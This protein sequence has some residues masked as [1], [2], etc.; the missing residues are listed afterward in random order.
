VLVVQSRDAAGCS[1]CSAG[2]AS[3]IKRFVITRS[4]FSLSLNIEQDLPLR[5]I[6]RRRI[7]LAIPADC[8]PWLTDRIGSKPVSFEHLHV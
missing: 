7:M 4:S 6:G 1:R 3:R 2:L 5:R 8:E